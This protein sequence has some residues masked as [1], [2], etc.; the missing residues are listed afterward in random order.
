MTALQFPSN[1]NT[2]DQYQQFEW[3]GD[4]WVG[5]PASETWLD[6]AT[7][8]QMIDT[9]T[10]D[11]A[12][13]TWV[14]TQIPAVPA[15]RFNVPMVFAYTAQPTTG[16]P[17][18]A[19]NWQLRIPIV[20]AVTIPLNPTINY[21]LGQPPSATVNYSFSYYSASGDSTN[22]IGVIEVDNNG[23]WTVVSGF[24]GAVNLVNGDV[25]YCDA[26]PDDD[27]SGAAITILTTRA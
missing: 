27:I 15:T 4:K 12:T 5:I 8:Q 1:P 2:G 17:S 10:A 3:D 16:L 7:A 19:L 20:S 23:E 24:S 9:A 14:A 18:G 25:L 6:Q 13:Q 26:N 22:A 21:S 11:M